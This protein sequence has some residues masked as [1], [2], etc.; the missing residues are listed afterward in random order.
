M[1]LSHTN[2]IV[3]YEVVPRTQ[4]H[5]RI[6]ATLGGIGAALL[7]TALSTGHALAA[8]AS[9][10]GIGAQVQNMAQEASTTG[11]FVSWTAMYVGA[12]ICFV[13]GVW[14]IWQSRQ[15]QNRSA[16]KLGM[17]LAGLA[18]CG[19]F[20]TGGVWIQK[21]ANTASGAN[22]TVTSNANAITF[23]Q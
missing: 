5:R 10:A 12:L 18:L 3:P 14:A 16:G 9:N 7:G 6:S 22:S 20:A 1:N 15:E 11:G 13:V 23:G 8:A 19:L 4:G 21:A 2:K 17:G